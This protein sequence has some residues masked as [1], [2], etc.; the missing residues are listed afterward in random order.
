MKIKVVEEDF[1]VIEVAD[2]VLKNLK[3]IS[4]QPYGI[5]SLK[6]KG[7]NTPEIVS[8]IA[9]YLRIKTKSIGFAGNKDKKAITSQYISIPI[10]SENE[11]EQVKNIKWDGVSLTFVGWSENRITL[12]DL[13]CNK[14]EVVVR[15]LEKEREL[16]VENVKNYFGVQRFGK[17]NVDVGRAIVKKEFEKAC[18]LIGLVCE[19]NNFVNALKTLDPR[20]LRFYVSAYQSWMWNK[21]AEKVDHVEDLELMGFLT[22]FEDELVAKHYGAILDTE[23]ITKEHFM[24]KQIKEASL[25]GT[26]RKLFMQVSNFSYVWGDDEI[27]DSK[28]K[29]TL[30]FELNKGS[31]ATVLVDFL[32]GPTWKSI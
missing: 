21:V 15:S 9:K 6:K 20:E 26:K 8:E 23:G 19:D 24:I 12:G 4:S 14:F 28:K 27:L 32:F 16:V 30:L 18:K 7:R 2:L 22:Q 25:E 3:E 29:C 17:I 11:V 5:F 31:Y 10:D 1:K 13:K